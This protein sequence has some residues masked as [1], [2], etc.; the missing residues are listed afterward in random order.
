MSLSNKKICQLLDRKLGDIEEHI[1]KLHQQEQNGL[2]Q[3]IQEL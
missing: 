2:A 1:A 3:E